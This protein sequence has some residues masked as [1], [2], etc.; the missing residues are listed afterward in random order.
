[1]TKKSNSLKNMFR[2][3]LI[4][5]FSAQVISLAVSLLISII[6]PKFLGITEYALWQVFIFY[7]NYVSF[8]QI[9]IVDGLYLKLGGRN[10]EELD[11]R[12]LGSQF[13]F[14]SLFQIIISIVIIVSAYCGLGV[15]EKFFVFLFVAI[16]LVVYNI[17]R[18]LGLIFQAV[19][20]T[21]WFS[22]ATMIDRIVILI[23]GAIA[24]LSRKVF[25]YGFAV[26]YLMGV[27]VSLTYTFYK[28][29]KIVICKSKISFRESILDMGDSMRIGV[30]LMISNLAG[31]LI[32]GCGRQFVE[33]KWG[34]DTFG[35]ISFALSITNF[36]LL[37]IN[38]ISLVMFPALRKIDE[39]T[40]KTIFNKLNRG[41][42]ILSPIVYL[43][44]IPVS[45]VLAKWLPQYTIS[46]SYLMILMPICVFDGKM[47]MIYT[48]YL[49]VLRMERSL[50]KINLFSLVLSLIC[51]SISVFILNDMNL[52][53]IFLVLI[54]LIRSNLACKIVSGKM[55]LNNRVS[56]LSDISFA[57]IFVGANL[58]FS[59]RVSF[60]IILL[61]YIPFV[62]M[63]S[64]F[65]LSIGKKGVNYKE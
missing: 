55:N 53:L 54:I 38:Q 5:A 30:N 58:L 14:F 45:F 7:T 49:K 32:L 40:G 6:V 18:F 36:F 15:T 10:Y 44:Y 60:I 24:I 63:N 17:S 26:I 3:N 12:Q 16:Y 64:D 43:F 56:T 51:C 61:F 25:W 19:N 33:F 52:L 39:N 47:Q 27:T 42:S 4:Y 8:G 28:G 1:M 48:T 37:F 57:V 34:L 62:F 59:K 9:G 65:L 2:S 13:Y 41:V 20:N 23:L 11:Y 22:I 50:L 46:L 31:T 21:K 35:M 29:K